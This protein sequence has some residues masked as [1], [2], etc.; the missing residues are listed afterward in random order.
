LPKSP[1]GTATKPG[2]Y[3]LVVTAT[4]PN[5]AVSSVNLSLNV[6]P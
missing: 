2:L 1:G 3:P 5:G 4:A 6:L